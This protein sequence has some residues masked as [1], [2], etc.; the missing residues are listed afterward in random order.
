MEQGKVKQIDVWTDW[1]R[2][3]NDNKLKKKNKEMKE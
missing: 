2:E 1:K 3:I